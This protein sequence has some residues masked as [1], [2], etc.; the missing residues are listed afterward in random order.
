MLPRPNDPRT[1]GF[2]RWAS[3]I[4]EAYN[5]LSVWR[6]RR[7]ALRRAGQDVELARLTPSRVM[8]RAVRDRFADRAL[9][10][11]KSPQDDRRDVE[12][13]AICLY[14][15]FLAEAL[16]TDC[17]G[18]KLP[19]IWARLEQQDLTSFY[20]YDEFFGAL[21]RE[22]TL[23]EPSRLT[24][25]LDL[26]K[27]FLLCVIGASSRTAPC[28]HYLDMC[29]A[30]LA[31]TPHDIGSIEHRLKG[32]TCTHY[33]F[34]SP[35]FLV[36]QTEETELDRRYN[37]VKSDGVSAHHGVSLVSDKALESLASGTLSI[38]EIKQLRDVDKSVQSVENVHLPIDN[39]S[40]LVECAKLK[41]TI[42]KNL[43]RAD[44]LAQELK[45]ARQAVANFM[46]PKY[47]HELP[48]YNY[49]VVELSLKERA[50]TIA[51]LTPNLRAAQPSVRT[52]RAWQ[53]LSYTSV[54]DPRY[55][56]AT[57]GQ[58]GILKNVSILNLDI[59][60][61]NEYVTTILPCIARSG[62]WRY[63]VPRYVFFKFY[64]SLQV[65]P[66]YLTEFRQH[67]QNLDL[68]KLLGSTLSNAREQIGDRTE[69]WQYFWLHAN[70]EAFRI[71]HKIVNWSRAG[72]VFENSA[73]LKKYFKI[74][75]PNLLALVIDGITI[76]DDI[77]ELYGL[78]LCYNSSSEIA[79]E[80]N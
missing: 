36:A 22:S 68:K 18:V 39:V 27:Q 47:L 1:D 56:A 45:E 44:T 41:T 62:S 15:S 40:V 28:L 20:K 5:C 58:A 38:L 2:G 35:R 59:T 78:L 70:L 3:D 21:C 16:E 23:L 75:S 80:E 14:I 12:L 6:H 63:Y 10:V 77:S 64:E 13:C 65:N 60:V 42:H 32:K 53:H 19:A 50:E 52:V 51:A 7:A 69:G 57:I 29:S 49:F 74:F 79:Q 37:M 66:R 33:A 34:V 4:E 11:F 76:V 24:A 72:D 54:N 30:C 9:T 48:L 25:R 71:I 61:Y 55:R 8:L 17:F 43:K 31:G 46:A 67:L 26:C 73:P